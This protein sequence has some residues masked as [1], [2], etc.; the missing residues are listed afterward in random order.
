MIDDGSVRDYHGTEAVIGEV[1]CT[2]TERAD[3]VTEEF[4]PHQNGVEECDAGYG[5]GAILIGVTA[6]LVSIEAAFYG[7][8]CSDVPFG[9]CRADLDA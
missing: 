1:R 3:W 7:G 8:R 5:F 9:G 2:L 4:L 6:D